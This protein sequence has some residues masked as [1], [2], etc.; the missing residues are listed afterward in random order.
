MAL[1]EQRMFGRPSDLAA[2]QQRGLVK[3]GAGRQHAAVA[4]EDLHEVLT[5]P[6]QWVIGAV[7]SLDVD[8]AHEA[9]DLLCAGPERLI[10][11]VVQIRAKVQIQEGAERRQQDRHHAREQ[12]CELEA[13]R[14]ASCEAQSGH[15]LYPTPRTV[16][17][18]LRLKGR[19]IF[20]RR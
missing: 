17:R 2:R 12:Q 3:P 13:D 14:Q 10:D 20:S 8:S 11:V 5:A 16:C 1:N 9:R 7:V 19:S 4:V 6:G 15:T 18:V